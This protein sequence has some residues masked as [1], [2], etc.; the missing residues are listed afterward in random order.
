MQLSYKHIAPFLQNHQNKVSRLF[1]YFGLCIGVLLL[2]AAVQMYI[3]IN[4]L[5]KEKTPRK[6]GFDY[7]SVTKIVTNENMGKDNRFSPADVEELTKQPFI[8]GVAPLISNQFKVVGSA[9]DVIPFSTDLFVE[10]LQDSYIDTVPPSFT[11]QPGS[12]RVPIILSSDFLEMYN[13]FAPSWDLPQLSE[14]TISSITLSLRCSGNLSEQVFSANI[15][16]LSDR[17]NSILVPQNFVEWAN[18]NLE[19]VVQ[20]STSRVYVKTTDANNPALLGYLQQKGYHVNKDKTKFGRVKQVLQAIVSGLA[21]FGVLV[22]LL[23]M[24]LFSFYLQLMIARSKENLELLLTLGYSPEWLSKTVSRQWIPVY[25]GIVI[26]ATL[27]T[28][29]LHFFFRATVMGSGDSLSPFIH[30]LVIVVAATLLVISIWINR[31]MV[32]KLLLRL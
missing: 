24:M 4:Q 6:T 18:Q 2:L 21:G 14:K 13:V 25:I 22:I 27:L 26:I 16:A 1:S 5:L 3:N 20:K 30:W 29:V 12:Q 19:G 9:G 17:I 10:S 15:V 23:A 31:R 11:W 8:Q 32:R 7:V 28:A